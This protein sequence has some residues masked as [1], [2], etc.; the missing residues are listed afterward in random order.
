MLPLLF[1]LLAESPVC[2]E[3][4]AWDAEDDDDESSNAGPSEEQP[5][6]LSAMAT[7]VKVPSVWR[8]KYLFPLF[9][10][11]TNLNLW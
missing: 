4:A 11:K 3:N 6:S 8:Y 9:F 2:A 5:L 10:S 1:P 7:L